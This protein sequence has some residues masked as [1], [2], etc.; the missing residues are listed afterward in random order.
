MNENDINYNACICPLIDLVYICIRA[1]VDHKTC[2]SL[3]FKGLYLEQN[4][5]YSIAYY[6]SERLLSA[7]LK[8]RTYIN[9]LIIELIKE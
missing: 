2:I 6:L 7:T 3:L 1:E 8:E 4:D 5:S 9:S